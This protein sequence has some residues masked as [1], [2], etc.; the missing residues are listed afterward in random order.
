MSDLVGNPEEG[1]SHDAVQLISFLT[2][3]ASSK[4]IQ[5]LTKHQFYQQLTCF[6]ISWHIEALNV[7][8][9]TENFEI[10]NMFN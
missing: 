4:I 10:N 5:Y 2:M 3:T 9:L 1:V 6:Q 7:G 8:E